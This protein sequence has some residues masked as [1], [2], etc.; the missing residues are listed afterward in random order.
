VRSTLDGRNRVA[1][2][3]SGQ[4]SGGKAERCRTGG[5]SGILWG[6]RASLAEV[7]LQWEV[8][9]NAPPLQPMHCRDEKPVAEGLGGGSPDEIGCSYPGGESPSW[10][11]VSHQPNSRTRRPEET[12][13]GSRGKQVAGVCMEPRKWCQSWSPRDKRRRG[14]LIPPSKPRTVSMCWNAASARRSRRAARRPPGSQIRTRQT[15]DNTGTR[16]SLIGLL[17]RKRGS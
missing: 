13:V 9:E 14:C 11:K 16:E 12:N 3:G 5:V 4:R 1:L 7:P 10:A 8:A 15:R 17:P 6:S 2:A